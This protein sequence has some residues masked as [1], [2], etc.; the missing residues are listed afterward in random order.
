MSDIRV[1]V[2]GTIAADAERVY[3]GLVDFTGVQPRVLPPNARDY[4]I[5]TGG[6]GEGTVAAFTLPVRGQDR[7]FS[8]RVA[9]PIPYRAITAYDHGHHLTITWRVRPVAET[10]E[11]DVEMYWTVA[12][13]R[14]VFLTQWWAKIVVRRMLVQMLG[15]LPPA[16]ADLVP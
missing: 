6:V 9:E 10:T 15:R 2:F 5:V 13:T 1:N 12:D 14:F 4:R 8:F 3:R 16:I 7:A 11:L